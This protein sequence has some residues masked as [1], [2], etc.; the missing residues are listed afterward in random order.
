MGAFVRIQYL[1]L[2]V[3]VITE[4]RAGMSRCGH[5]FVPYLPL[6]CDL[7]YGAD[8]ISSIGDTGKYPSS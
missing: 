8:W 1:S 3:M 6:G 4:R 5:D 7:D 2:G